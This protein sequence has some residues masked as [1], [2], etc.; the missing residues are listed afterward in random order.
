MYPCIYK[1]RR[2]ITLDPDVPELWDA[3]LAVQ[4]GRIVAVGPWSE[5]KSCGPVHDLGTVTLVPGLINAHTHLE[6]SHLAGAIPQGLG[7]SAWADSLFALLRTSARKQNSAQS[8]ND[9]VGQGLACVL[10]VCSRPGH[11]YAQ[12]EQAGIHIVSV[13]EY[14]GRVRKIDDT[15]NTLTWSRAA[16]ALYSTQ[17]EF[18]VQLKQW[19]ENQGKVFSIHLAE[20]PGENDFFVHGQG[21]FAEFLRARRIL[22]KNFQPPG[23]SAVA[24]AKSLG[25]LNARTLAVHCVHVDDADIDVLA[26]SGTRV[27][28]CLRSNAWIGVGQ[29][30]VAALHEAEIPLCVGTDSLASNTDLDIW[31]ELRAVRAVLPTITLT[32]LLAMATRIPAELLGLGQEYGRLAVGNRACWAVLPEDW[33]ELPV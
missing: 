21:Q 9:Y 14:A 27:C 33:A 4:H 13:Q 29:P 2:I 28:L 24:Y 1:A 6:L 15:A 8:F 7:F 11:T 31:A 10:D 32:E 17:A 22:L 3:G 25:V 23:L 18:V 30:P 26:H 12:L 5:L 19:C 16:H 20:V